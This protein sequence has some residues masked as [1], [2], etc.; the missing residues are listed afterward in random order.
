MFLTSLLFTSVTFIACRD[1]PNKNP[2]G[3]KTLSQDSRLNYDTSTTT[4]IALKSKSEWPF[5]S[6]CKAT[7]LTQDNLQTIDTLLLRCIANYN[8]SLSNN[9]EQWG[10]DLVKWNYKKQL[11]AVINKDGQK[12][13][14]VNCFCNT[15]DNDQWKTEILQVD[16]GGTCYFNFKINLETKKYYALIVNGVA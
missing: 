15:W 13:V 9:K 6:T 5:D 12:E 3:E 10:I 14:W 1:L 2:A 7:V 8:N 11:V 16:D 4:I